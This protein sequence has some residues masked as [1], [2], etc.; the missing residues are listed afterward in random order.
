MDL[1]MIHSSRVPLTSE[2][3]PCAVTLVTESRVSPNRRKLPRNR[4]NQQRHIGLT[5]P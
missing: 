1:H 5:S 3:P 4:I 2:E